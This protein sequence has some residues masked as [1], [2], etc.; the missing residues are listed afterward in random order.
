MQALTD[1]ATIGLLQE[2][3]IRRGEVLTE[4]LQSALNS[5]VAIEQ[6]KGALARTHGVSVDSAFELIR[7]YARQHNRKLVDLARLVV[8][9]P[10]SV[11]DLMT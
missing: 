10:A 9:K 6:A 11:P 3:A 4:Q 2:R 7:G 5:R 1:V 8:T